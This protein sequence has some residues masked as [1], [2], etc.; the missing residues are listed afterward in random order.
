MYSALVRISSVRGLPGRYRLPLFSL[1]LSIVSILE[2]LVH[3]LDN[4]SR[5][6][7]FGTI[8]APDG[9]SYQYEQMICYL[10]S[11]SDEFVGKSG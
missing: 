3:R 11:M 7:S 5:V 6:P 9:K 8:L 10:P 2:K 1:H 4:A